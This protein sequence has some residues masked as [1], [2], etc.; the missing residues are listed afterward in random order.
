MTQAKNIPQSIDD[1][2]DLLP[3][4][5]FSKMGQS[6]RGKHAKKIREQG[7]SVTVHHEDGTST[8]TYV[9]PEDIANRDRRTN[10]PANSSTEA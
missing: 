3:E 6:I 8:T 10:P 4:C 2:D 5:D 7:Y 9:T 1:G